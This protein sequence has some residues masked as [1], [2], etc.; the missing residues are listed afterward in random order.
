[1]NI[2]ITDEMAIELADALAASYSYDPADLKHLIDVVGALLVYI[3]DPRGATV[4]VRVAAAIVERGVRR[5]RGKLTPH[6]REVYERIERISR[7]ISDRWVAA[8]S[9]GSAGACAHLVAKGWIE[10]MVE[11]GP[12]GG[13]LY[14]YRP[15]STPMS[16][17]VDNG[18]AS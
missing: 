13:E 12:R 1:M 14:R 15:L 11:Y 18:G 7:R 6:Q 2:E 16:T 8:R 9:I 10:R 17:P 3:P 4:P 5:P